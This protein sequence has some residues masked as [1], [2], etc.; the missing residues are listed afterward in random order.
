[1][2]IINQFDKRSGITYVYESISY[3]DKDKQQSR[4]KRTLIGKRDP[5]TNEIIPTD[6]RGKKKARDSTPVVS[7]DPVPIAETNRRFYGATY[8]L[9]EISRKT[10]LVDDLKKCFPST[11]KQ[12]L[13]IAYYL[14]LEHDSPLSR[15]ERWHTLHHHP[16]GK[17]LTSQR[18][19][20]LFAAVTEEGT[21]TF[22]HCQKQRRVENEYWAYDTTSVSSYSQALKQVQYGKNKEDDRLPQLNLALLFGQSSGLPFY[23]R[24]LAGNIPDMS[25]IQGLLADFNVLGFDKVKLVMDHGFY[26]RANVNAL[27]K[28][29]LKFILATKTSLS[30][31]RQAIDKVDTSIH[32]YECLNEQYELYMKTVRFEWEYAQ[33]RPYKKD[34]LSQKRRMYLHIY[35]NIDKRAE[36]EMA[37]DR[38]LLQRRKDVLESKRKPEHE[39]YY[40]TYFDIK[41]TPKRAPQVHVKT[42]AVE[43]AKRYFGYFVLLSNEKMTASE[44]LVIYRNKDVVEKAFGNVK[45]RL[46]LRRLLVSSEKSLDG[47][48]F[49]SFI[50]LILTSYIKK[51]MEKS[52]LFKSYTR[53]SLIDQ[54]DVIECF[55]HPGHGLRVGEVLTRQKAIYEALEITPPS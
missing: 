13:S 49:V 22:F 47:K 6:G 34:T 54:L 26:S 27:L 29:H 42:E 36:D 45:E 33:E 2:A 10:G 35:F 38:K 32:S 30:Y 31:V 23:Y 55:E 53:Q 21:N 7:P 44:A 41:E 12:L 20:E 43:K 4:A 40:K 14:V 15:F 37:F 46:N 16:Y 25:T 11:Y 28:E 24:K 17:Q 52:G 51:N 3:W 50:G 19:S 1:M 18:T 9:D 8:L 48:L 39:S 5:L